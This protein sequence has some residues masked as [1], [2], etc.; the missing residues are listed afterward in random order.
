MRGLQAAITRVPY[1]GAVDERLGLMDS[2]Y[3]YTAGGAWAAHMENLV[4]AVK[5]G[6][7]GDLVLLDGDIE[8]VAADEIGRMGIALTICGGRITHQGVGFGD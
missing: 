3:A 4:G 8:A 1:E 2:L 7:A 5:V 6:L